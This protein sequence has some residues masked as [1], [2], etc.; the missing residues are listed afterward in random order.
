MTDHLLDKT[1]DDRSIIDYEH[2]FCPWCLIFLS[3][4]P[5]YLIC[6]ICMH[7]PLTHNLVLSMTCFVYAIDDYGL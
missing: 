1:T 7:F 6:S 3:L 4:W 2:K 5:D